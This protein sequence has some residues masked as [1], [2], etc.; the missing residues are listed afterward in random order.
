M[1]PEVAG[2]APVFHPQEWLLLNGDGTGLGRSEV[3]VV[4]ISAGGIES[5]GNGFAGLKIA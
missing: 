3:V 4:L 1:D 5:Q 2:A